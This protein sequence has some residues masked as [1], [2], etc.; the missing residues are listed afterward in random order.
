MMTL[1]DSF[2][3]VL[4]EF[5]ETLGAELVLKDGECIFTV[6]GNIDVVIDY[7]EESDVV[8]A[9]STV[10]ILPEDEY[11][12]ERARA[13]FALNELDAPNGGFSVSMDPETRLVI[14][15][16]H[17]PVELFDSADRLAAWVDA[18]VDLVNLI[19]DTFE[20]KFPCTEMPLDDEDDENDEEVEEA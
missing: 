20:E 13:L 4:N 14:V 12:D 11:Q 3:M 16:D 7:Y 8:I 19:R 6:D 15:Q 2:N 5:G 9:W 17:R 10:G 18:L 1:Y